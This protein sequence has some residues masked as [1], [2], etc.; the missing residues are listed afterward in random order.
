MKPHTEK[1]A[2]GVWETR[3]EDGSKYMIDGIGDLPLK[4]IYIGL[5]SI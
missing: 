5:I 2:G 1:N 3:E 4:N